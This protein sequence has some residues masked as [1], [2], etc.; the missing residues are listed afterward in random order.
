MVGLMCG[1]L[2]GRKNVFAL[3]RRIIRQNFLERRPV[4]DQFQNIRHTN[5]LT[6]NTR[7]PPALPCL[8][9]NPPQPFWIHFLSLL[10]GKKL[11]TN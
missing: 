10:C 5:P 6:P 9:R 11:V 7:T 1:I 4:G 8:D 2:N 3:K